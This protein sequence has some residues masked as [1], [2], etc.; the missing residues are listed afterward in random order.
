MV[1]NL[2][3][4]AGDPEDTVLI[5]GSRRSPEEGSS[6]QLQHSYLGNPMDRGDCRPWSM[7]SQRVEHD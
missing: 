5:P 7:D 4:N 6:D 3:T 2:P 1:K